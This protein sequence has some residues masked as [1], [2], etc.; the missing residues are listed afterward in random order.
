MKIEIDVNIG[1][2]PGTAALLRGLLAGSIRPLAAGSVRE[3]AP[4]ALT[5]AA[6]ADEP[7]AEAEAAGAAGA[8]VREQA[9]DALTEAAAEAPGLVAD[10]DALRYWMDQRIEELAGPK[11]MVSKEPSVL[12]IRR[13]CAKVFKEIAR[14]LG[15]EKPTALPQEKRDAFVGH[16]REVKLEPGTVNVSWKPF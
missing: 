9:P 12:Q 2:K 4:D 8:A 3:Q 15:A 6:A 13:N 10:D 5:E 11:W 1:L 16:L 7:E 14:F